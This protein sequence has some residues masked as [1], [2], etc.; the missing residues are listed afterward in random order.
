MLIAILTALA[1]VSAVLTILASSQ[2]RPLTLYLFKPLTIIFIIVI[3]VQPKHPVSTFYGYAIL[4][5]LV[6]SLVG[7]VFL[8]L[9]DE[10]FIA[11]LVSFLAAHICYITAFMYES[12]LARSGLDL[13]PFLLYGALMLRVLWPHLGKMRAPDIVYMIIILLMGWAAASRWLIVGQEGSRLAF[14]GAVLFIISDSALAIDR[15]N[16]RFRSAQLLI[17]ST[18]FTAQWLIALST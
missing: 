13:I 12:G 1:F 6:F 14:I 4:A 7:D 17:L 5:G 10:Q 11:G 3:A 9:P 15:F 18:Y 2:K 16:G 8:M